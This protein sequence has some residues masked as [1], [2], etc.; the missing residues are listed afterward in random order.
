MS[1]QTIKIT[2]EDNFVWKIVTDRALEI[3]DTELFCLYA[4]HGD[5]TESLVMDKEE[6]QDYLNRGFDIGIEVGFI[7]PVE[8]SH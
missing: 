3:W 4:L 5:D 8:V 1:K 7:N 6:L 2:Q